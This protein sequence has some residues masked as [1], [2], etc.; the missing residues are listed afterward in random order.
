MALKGYNGLQPCMSYIH[1]PCFR[2]WCN[3][4]YDVQVAELRAAT[5]CLEQHALLAAQRAKREQ[6]HVT[7]QLAHLKAEV[8]T[9][10]EDRY[11]LQVGNGLHV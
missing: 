7:E 4:G 2:A 9:L 1:T 5:T 6:Q 10:V 11:E 3:E 8:A